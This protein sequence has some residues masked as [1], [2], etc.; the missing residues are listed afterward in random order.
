MSHMPHGVTMRAKGIA[1][2][3]CNGWIH[4]IRIYGGLKM[5][6]VERN[7][8]DLKDKADLENTQARAAQLLALLEYNVM[9]G[10]IEDPAEEYEDE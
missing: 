7:K 4:F 5:T 9:M 3:Y 8:M 6:L 2:N 1:T 10:N